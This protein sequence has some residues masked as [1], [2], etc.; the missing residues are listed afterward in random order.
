[1]KTVGRPK[2]GVVGREVTLLPRH[3]EW[4]NSRPGGASV[5][6]RKLVDQARKD[7]EAS[8]RIRLAQESTYHLM[9][10]AAGD[11][12]GYEEALRALFAR[13][14]DRFRAEIAG[15]PEIVREEA[16]RRASDVW[17]AASAA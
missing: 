17:P 12:P 8:D 13:Q 6:L 11:L 14:E 3:W 10:E 1:M 15:W 16:L 2:L 5:A 4:L 7:S 9:T